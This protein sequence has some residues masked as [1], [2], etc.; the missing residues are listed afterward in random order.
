MLAIFNQGASSCLPSFA[1]VVAVLRRKTDTKV[2]ILYVC[3]GSGYKVRSVPESPKKWLHA[4]Q[5]DVLLQSELVTPLIQ[6]L[7]ADSAAQ[8]SDSIII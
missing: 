7:L 8:Q 2:L 3:P 1:L 4:V 5:R 6:L